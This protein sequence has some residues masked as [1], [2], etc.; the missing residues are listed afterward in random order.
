LAFTWATNGN[1]ISEPGVQT[2][3][4]EYL[5]TTPNYQV[6]GSLFTTFFGAEKQY[7]AFAISP[8][9]GLRYTASWGLTLESHFGFGY[10]YRHFDYHQYE[11]DSEGNIV[12]KGNAGIS[13]MLPNFA[14]G[15]GYDFSRKAN[16]PIKLYIRP[17]CNLSYPEGHILFQA[18]YALEAGI[19]FI[20]QLNKRELKKN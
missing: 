15:L 1:K 9:I 6:I 19:I 20:P 17:S 10:I 2:G 13:S 7:Y 4:E 14:F 8:R 11:L 12:D 3:V 5:A 16:L 18:S